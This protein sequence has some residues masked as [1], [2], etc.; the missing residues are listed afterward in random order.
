MKLKPKPRDKAQRPIRVVIKGVAPLGGLPKRRH[1]KGTRPPWPLRVTA[2]TLGVLLLGL[3]YALFSP[4]SVPGVTQAAAADAVDEPPEAES[5]LSAEA[6]ET[7]VAAVVAVTAQPA[8]VRDDAVAVTLQSALVP[9]GGGLCPAP[10]ETLGTGVAWD[11][12]PVT[13][14][15]RASQEDK[16][17]FLLHLSGNFDTPDET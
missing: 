11:R 10:T 1:D 15:Q 5:A 4:N 9:V 2:S 8:P 7:A 12:N 3:A 16:L 17:V 6:T 13:A 14:F